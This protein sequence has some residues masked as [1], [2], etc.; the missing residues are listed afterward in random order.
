MRAST[1]SNLYTEIIGAGISAT[2]AHVRWRFSMPRHHADPRQARAADNPRRRTM[3]GVHIPS[4]IAHEE[5]A[6]RRSISAQDGIE[7]TF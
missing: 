6:T 5:S 4:P 7:I 1:R 2:V 3:G